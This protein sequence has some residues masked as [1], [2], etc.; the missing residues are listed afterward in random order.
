[1]HLQNPG[2]HFRKMLMK[3]VTLLHVSFQITKQLQENYVRKRSHAKSV[4]PKQSTSK[5]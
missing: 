4:E 2:M 1:M 3:D 5:S